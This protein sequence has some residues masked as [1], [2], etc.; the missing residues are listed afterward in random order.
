M[1]W[2][3]SL[4]LGLVIVLA[5]T[6]ATAYFVAQEFAYMSVDR[7]GLTAAASAGDPG[8]KR[9]LAITRRTSS[10]PMAAAAVSSFTGPAVCFAVAAAMA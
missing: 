10:G 7:A 4:L 5:I 8:A 6:A 3:L 2:P 1:I 9:A